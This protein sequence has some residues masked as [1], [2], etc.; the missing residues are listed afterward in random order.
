[1]LRTSARL[2]VSGTLGLFLT[3]ACAKCGGPPISSQP[4]QWVATD[5][6]VMVP[7]YDPSHHDYEGGNPVILPVRA[8]GA[9]DLRCPIEQVT[10]RNLHPARGEMYA[11][12]GCDLRAVY[13]ITRRSGPAD[14]FDCVLTGIVPFAK[15]EA[16]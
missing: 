1:V 9:H 8:S 7:R 3:A 2:A 10:A 4:A 15:P 6:Q 14:V 11:A 5:G 13:L 16:P 12:E